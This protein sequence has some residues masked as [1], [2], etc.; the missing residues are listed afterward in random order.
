MQVIVEAHAAKPIIKWAGGKRW[1]LELIEPY[2]NG[3]RRLIDPFLGGGSIPLHYYSKFSSIV[4]SDLN[5]ALIE[6]YEVVRLHPDRVA[7]AL[8]Q[9]PTDEESYYMVRSD[10]KLGPMWQ[11]SHTNR[12]ARFIYLNKTCFNGLYRVNRAGQFNVPWGK[13]TSVKFPSLVELKAVALALKNATLKTSDYKEVIRGAK[14]GDLVIADP[15]YFKTFTSYTKTGFNYDE[16]VKLA[17]LLRQAMKRGAK[18]IA[19]NSDSSETRELYNWA[20]ITPVTERRN[21]NRDGAGRGGKP[22]LLITA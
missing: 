4:L 7:Q 1:A 19:F 18:F 16:Q 9:F 6:M 2:T 22:C 3:H 14:K 8:K 20:K 10:P 17:Y 5:E 15:P 12:A 11:C 13:R 21:I